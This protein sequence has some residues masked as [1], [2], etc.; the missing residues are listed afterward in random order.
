MRPFP[1]CLLLFVFASSCPALEGEPRLPDGVTA[2]DFFNQRI[3]PVL[4]DQCWRC[5]G[6]HKQR[7]GLR[8]DSRDAVLQGGHIVDVNPGHPE[9]SRLIDAIGTEDG[10]LH[11]P[12]DATLSA[13]QIADFATWVRLGV[14]WAEAKAGGA[15]SWP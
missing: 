2:E 6:Q 3:R 15:C 7:N 4:A 10:D 8:L 1:A 5:H 12:P 14:P 13:A 9:T 11:M